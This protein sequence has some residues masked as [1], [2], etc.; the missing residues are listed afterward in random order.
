MTIRVDGRRDVGRSGAAEV[1]PLG[2]GAPTVWTGVLVVLTV[3]DEAALSPAVVL[4]ATAELEEVMLAE[5]EGIML[6]ELGALEVCSG[7]VL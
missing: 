5:S 2:W 1:G 3:G 7:V 6:I 4:V